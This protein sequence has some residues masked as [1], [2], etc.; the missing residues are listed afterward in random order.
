[1]IHEASV[2]G[3]WGITI[4]T[5]LA[6]SFGMP[7]WVRAQGA[8][9]QKPALGRGRSELPGGHVVYRYCD[10]AQTLDGS[11]LRVASYN[12]YKGGR[13]RGEKDGKT[14]A[15]SL[16]KV[17]STLRDLGPL[18]VL[19]LQ[20]VEVGGKRV[21][22]VDPADWIAHEFGLCGIFSVAHDFGKFG[23]AMGTFGNAIFSRAPFADFFAVRFDQT[24]RKNLKDRLVFERRG[25][26]GL[27]I[28][29]HLGKPGDSG[30]LF[31]FSTHLSPGWVQPEQERDRLIQVD[32]IRRR[33]E[34]ALKQGRTVLMGDLN[35]ELESPTLRT[36]LAPWEDSKLSRLQS[37]NDLTNQRRVL[38]YAGHDDPA[39]A[40]TSQLDHFV[41]AGFEKA[42]GFHAFRRPERGVQGSDHLPIVINLKY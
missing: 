8:V 22:G 16:S 9:W 27:R 37:A 31:V 2:L 39:L 7:G 36:L 33:L 15:Y 29:T 28:R 19:G 32:Q 1:M 10:P 14:Y 20:E 5:F 41:L 30:N 34:P 17:I 4:A 23:F 35:A 21:G 40:P 38:T 11:S 18:D 42:S 13:W 26:A 25:M 24:N 12:I 6:V 3:I